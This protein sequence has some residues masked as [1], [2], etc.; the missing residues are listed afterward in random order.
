[1]RLFNLRHHMLSVLVR[2]LHSHLL[3]QCYM[4]QKEV[5]Q[6][7]QRRQW[8][9]SIRY[10][11]HVQWCNGYCYLKCPRSISTRFNLVKIDLIERL[12]ASF[13]FGIK[14]N[15][16]GFYAMSCNIS[17]RANHPITITCLYAVIDVLI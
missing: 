3:H 12:K 11:Y 4:L 1:M 14:D 8:Q 6:R 5:H 7:Q 9:H 10:R 13:H 2:K 17:C 16:K 15:R